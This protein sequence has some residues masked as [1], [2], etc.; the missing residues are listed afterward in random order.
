MFSKT[1]CIYRA[2]LVHYGILS[3]ASYDSG[4]GKESKGKFGKNGRFGLKAVYALWATISDC[5]HATYSG[6]RQTGDCHERLAC[7]HSVDSHVTIK[8]AR[9]YR[10][11]KHD[12]NCHHPYLCIPLIG[13]LVT[14]FVLQ[15]ISSSNHLLLTRPQK[16]STSSS[17]STFWRS[18]RMPEYRQS[19]VVAGPV[20]GLCRT[21]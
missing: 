18:L 6:D 14:I 15:S 11:I 4:T 21:D 20:Y 13:V 10:I 2:L 17:A 7:K 8:Q 12:S 9:W 1:S 19:R 5:L 3:S 16:A